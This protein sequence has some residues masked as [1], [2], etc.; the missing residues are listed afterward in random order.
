MCGLLAACDVTF[1]NTLV[2]NRRYN[3]SRCNSPVLTCCRRPQQLVDIRSNHRTKVSIHGVVMQCYIISIML[4]RDSFFNMFTQLC[5]CLFWDHLFISS[6][7]F[8][9]YSSY[10]VSPPLLSEFFAPRYQPLTN[11][12][13]CCS[14]WHIIHV[15]FNYLWPRLIPSAGWVWEPNNIALYKSQS[16]SVW[17][18]LSQ[19]YHRVCKLKK[20]FQESS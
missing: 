14:S 16:P 17:I 1:L 15:I 12:P 10:Y 8:V 13:S 9:F 4:T 19:S 11:P 18:C 6:L 2:T 20:K 5:Y 3:C 7:S